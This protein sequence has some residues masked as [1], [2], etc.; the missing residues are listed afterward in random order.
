M[1]IFEDKYFTLVTKQ[2]VEKWRGTLIGLLC[3]RITHR[4]II[5]TVHHNIYL[6]IKLVSVSSGRK[7]TA[8][9]VRATVHSL[10]KSYHHIFFPGLSANDTLP[11]DKWPEDFP[12]CGRHN[13]SPI[14]FDTSRIQ[15]SS[16]LTE[17][18]FVDYDEYPPQR[19]WNILNNGHTGI[20]RVFVHAVYV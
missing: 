6:F 11:V 5:Y 7:H 1:H 13:Q 17:I 8:C 12:K 20:F 16:T 9:K 2:C 4:I 3:M 10:G 19:T 18:L 14:N 15:P